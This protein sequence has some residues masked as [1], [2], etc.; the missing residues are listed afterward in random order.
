MLDAVLYVYQTD[1]TARTVLLDGVRVIPGSVAD[2]FE[3]AQWSLAVEPDTYVT[4][5]N[6]AGTALSVLSSV[7]AAAL[8]RHWVR[9]TLASPWYVYVTAGRA[10]AKTSAET[11]NDDLAD[12]T[13]AEI[14]RASI[15]N[16]V[17]VQW[18]SATVWYTDPTSMTK[19]GPR[20]SQAVGGGYGD[21]ATV[22]ASIGAA[23]LARYKDPR[24]RPRITVVNRF[25][26]QL[27]RELDDLVTVNF[28]R[29]GISGGKYLI[30]GIT[31][32]ISQN[33]NWWETAYQLEEFAS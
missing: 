4:S 10:D 13:A 20:P 8:S 2:D 24:A 11:F 25:P 31:T 30:L 16:I 22:A 7:N 29:L 33:G 17:P 6:L 19:Y 3:M 18:S 28:A 5:A 26:S 21:S 15:I 12:M 14:D 32:S 9:P 23:V 27:Q 1:S